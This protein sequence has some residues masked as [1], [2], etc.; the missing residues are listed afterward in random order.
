MNGFADQGLSEDSFGPTSGGL[1]AFDAFRKSTMRL[2]RRL[3]ARAL[4]CC[5]SLQMDH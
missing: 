4:H 3:A 5:C 2:P 1:K